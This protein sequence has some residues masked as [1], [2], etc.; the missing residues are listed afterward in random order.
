MKGA[1]SES[2]SA[3]L[4]ALRPVRSSRSKPDYVGEV[5]SRDPPKEIERFSVVKGLGKPWTNACQYN[6]GRRRATVEFSDLERLDEGEW[7]NDAL[8]EFYTL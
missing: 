4:S 2:A 1:R 8:V 3:S 7:L 5:S 6:I